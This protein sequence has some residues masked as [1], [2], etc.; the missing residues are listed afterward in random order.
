MAEK[1]IV[2]HRIIHAISSQL[3]VNILRELKNRSLTVTELSK[4]LNVSKS[5]I[6]DNLSVLM[7]ANLIF[8]K[9]TNRKWVYY[10][11]SQE[12]EDLVNSYRIN[13]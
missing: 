3:R 9:K 7:D 11:L 12:G 5:T 8:I 2:D 4:E 13:Y 10:A 6:H 1:T